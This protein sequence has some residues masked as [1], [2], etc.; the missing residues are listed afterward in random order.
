MRGMGRGYRWVVALLN[1]KPRLTA[2][3]HK[4]GSEF[5]RKMANSQE[6]YADPARNLS[7]GTIPRDER[8]SSASVVWLL[9]STES[10]ALLR[11]KETTQSLQAKSRREQES[12][13]M[14]M[15]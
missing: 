8:S 3:K 11:K 10:S 13:S 1:L 5:T 6:S 4:L 15:F 12:Q 7:G 2:L 14:I 9:K